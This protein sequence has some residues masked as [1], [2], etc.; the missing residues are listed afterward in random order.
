[1]KAMLDLV[2][3]HKSGQA[4][5]IYSVCSAHPLV[6]EA[7][8]DHA[9]KADL[10]VLLIESTCNQVNQDGGYTGM[11]PDLFRDFVH[12]I[13]RKV[14]FPVERILLGGDHLG[15]NP[16]TALP[17]DAAMAK[18][19]VLIEQYVAAGFRKIHADCS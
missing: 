4:C 9:L 11:T 16:W 6:I 14:S 18:A 1:M 5:G 10:G 13:A 17:A 8:C 2:A 12:D 7:A 19:D 3:R 15:P